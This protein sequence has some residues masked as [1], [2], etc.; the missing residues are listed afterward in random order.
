M[1]SKRD[2]SFKQIVF[3]ILEKGDKIGLKNDNIYVEDKDGNVKLEYTCYRISIVYIVGNVSITSGILSKA[4][5]FGFTMCFMKPNFRIYQIISNC[6]EGNTLLRKKQYNYNGLLLGKHIIKNKILNQ[7]I[8]I[9]HIRKKDDVQKSCVKKLEENIQKID[10][11]NSIHEIMGIEGISSR[12]YFSALFEDIGWNG[13]K[14]RVKRDYINA[15]L[16]IAYTILFEFV[17]SMLIMFGFDTFYGILHTQFY[18]RKSLTCDIIEVFRPYIDLTVKKSIN[19]NQFKKE[20][21][22]I[23]NDKYMLKYTESK[24]YAKVISESIYQ[25]RDIMYDYIHKYYL[26][27]MKEYTS[28][29][30]PVFNLSEIK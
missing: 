14:P 22:K 15:I 28:D 24:K 30:F 7:S 19:L 13:R 17:D 11:C 2:F 5:T 9:K 10:F 12:M 16:D 20:D 27:F 23:I 1:I 29:K 25:I 6:G 26:S 21:F 18:M 8:T 4:K 3:L